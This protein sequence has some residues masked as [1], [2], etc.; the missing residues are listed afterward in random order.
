MRI[1]D[2]ANLKEW[3]EQQWG[4]AALGDERRTQR[5]VAIGQAIAANP[6][7]SLPEQML[8]W[9]NLKAAYRLLSETDVSHRA[10]SQPHW[11]NTRRQAKGSDA[12][13]VLFVQD[14]SELDY[15][16]QSQTKDLGHIGDSH[17]RGLMLHSCLAVIPTPGNAEILGLAAQRV[18]RRTEIRKGTETRAQRATRRTEADVWAEVVEAIGVAPTAT[19]QLWVSV[20]DRGSD[21]FSDLRR[22][23]AMNWHCLFRACQDRV[24][25]DAEG[26]KGRLI[27]RARTLSAMAQ[28]TLALRSRDGQPKQT[29]DLQVAWFPVEIVPPVRG[30]ERHELPQSGWCI[31]VWQATQHPEALEWILFTTV[32]VNDATDA[33]RQVEWYA[34]RWTIEEYHK[35]LKTGCAVEQRQLKTADRLERLLGFLARVAVRLLQLRPLARTYPASLAQDYVPTVMLN[36]LVARLQL[37]HTPRTLTEFWHALARLGGFIGRKGDGSPGWQTLWRGWSRL[38]DFCWAASLAIEES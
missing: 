1:K 24:I 5:A 38:Q 15:S 16:R 37:P 35:C 6:D 12:E 21:L 14:T 19:Q 23:K 34:T 11:E 3:A 33:L 32:V 4:Q 9:G 10:L 7:A 27:Q 36:I 25:V 22:S 13:V 30:T 8:S 28:T 17:G 29:L 2:F 18:W 26:S 20:G 31:R